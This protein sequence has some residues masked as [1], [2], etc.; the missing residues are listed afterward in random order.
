MYTETKVKE[1]VEEAFNRGGD[2]LFEYVTRFAYD[3]KQNVTGDRI[4][5]SKS[6]E[7]PIEG[8][9]DWIKESI[10]NKKSMIKNII[11]PKGV[12]LSSSDMEDKEIDKKVQQIFEN[13]EIIQN[14]EIL[15]IIK[16]TDVV[17]GS[18]CNDVDKIIVDAIGG[19]AIGKDGQ[20]IPFKEE[21]TIKVDEGSLENKSCEGYLTSKKIRSAV[22]KL[23]FRSNVVC[24]ASF[25]AYS[26][27]VFE[28]M[29]LNTHT[30]KE[31]K[32]NKKD[33]ETFEVLFKSLDAKIF[34]PFAGIDH[35]I[36][37]NNMP[38]VEGRPDLEYAYVYDKS[39]IWLGCQNGRPFDVKISGDIAHITTYGC[40]RTDED[41][42]VRIEVKTQ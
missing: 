31:L 11:K 4:I 12:L 42:V 3:S 16:Q 26:Q 6:F 23:G 32:Q 38:K 25:N 33:E 37:V 13:P 22:A 17:H 5:I 40:T 19:D 24:V 10:I 29:I 35:W 8:L 7:Y 1:W 2:N 36:E 15:K 34:P 39:K 30:M 41:A 20:K 28:D 18:K 14:P 9:R 21:N 27:L